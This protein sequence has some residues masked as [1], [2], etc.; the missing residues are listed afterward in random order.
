MKK[1]FKSAFSILAAVVLLTAEFSFVFD[2]TD[3]SASSF[4]YADESVSSDASDD[5]SASE[6]TGTEDIISFD[7]DKDLKLAGEE[8]PSPE[9]PQAPVNQW[10]GIQ[11][12]NKSKI[13]W[14]TKKS[15]KRY[16]YRALAKQKMYGY[17]TF[18]GACTHGDYSYHIL[19]NRRNQK[20]KVI[21]VS[22][23]THKVVKVSK[24]LPLDHG[25]DMTYDTKN[26]RL[27]VVHYEP[28]P[29]RLSV[30]DPETLER[31]KVKNVKRPTERLSGA[32]TALTKSIKGMTGIGYDEE[33]DEFIVSIMGT[34][35]YMLLS[36]SFKPTSV[37]KVP[38]NDPYVKQGMTVKDGFIIRSFSAY[39][40]KYNQNILYIYDFAGNFV[41]TVKLGKGYEIENVYFVDDKLYAST[42]MSYF[43]KITKKVKRYVTVRT[44][45]GRKV[46]KKK[47]VKVTVYRLRRDNNI[48]R[49]MEY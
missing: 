8:D 14:L 40:R 25:N 9:D 46:R 13:T 15:G 4:A 7:L 33:H 32:S 2:L 1:S 3:P 45:S 12:S 48:M 18:Q 31:T 28:H 20:C 23:K 43:K 44:K 11:K 39:N 38:K 10:F 30:I 34:R 35:H 29:M 37:I 24:A 21:K 41:K 5:A 49:I 17:D 19:Y 26:D 27:V 36:S 22:L 47:K 42:Y 6:A 16:E